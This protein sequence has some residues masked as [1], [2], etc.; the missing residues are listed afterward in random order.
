MNSGY[1][2]SGLEMRSSY[3]IG[4]F[5][6]T[7]L[8]IHYSWLLAFILI[9]LAVST[10][11]SVDN[12]FW[13]RVAA[14][15]GAAALYFGAI[16]VREMPLILMAL[17]KG[18]DVKSV[19]FFIFGGL[20]EVDQKTTSAAH[21]MLLSLV[22]FFVNLLIA[23]IFYLVSV[24]AARF[25]TLEI[26][27]KWLAFLFFTLS[28]FHIVPG[29]PLEGGRAFRSLLWRILDNGEKSLKIANWVSWVLGLMIAVGGLLFILFTVERL[30]GVFFL[31]AGLVLQNAATHSR[32]TLAR[33]D[34][35]ETSI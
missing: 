19:T 16:I 30:M 1:P 23:G 28:L 10:Q 21:E 7:R 35:P 8:R 26:I 33:K 2:D 27:T 31:I 4:R 25:M 22:G 12:P 17:Y 20:L 34:V 14:G 13:M 18:I 9:T 11:F 32:R 5:L 15:A 6:R 24:L 29:Y 3:T